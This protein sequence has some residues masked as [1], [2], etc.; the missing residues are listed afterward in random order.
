MKHFALLSVC[1][2]GEENHHA[3][4]D[5]E[6]VAGKKPFPSLLI[7]ESDL[8]TPAARQQVATF[9]AQLHH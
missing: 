8:E 9:V 6:A 2:L 1:G 3:L 4:A 7:K 5:V